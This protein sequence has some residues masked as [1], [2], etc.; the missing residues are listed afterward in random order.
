MKRTPDKTSAFHLAFRQDQ[1]HCATWQI[2]YLRFLFAVHLH[3]T[4]K[5]LAG[6]TRPPNDAYP[7]S[8]TGPPI[9][10]STDFKYDLR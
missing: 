2:S 5:L 1:E 8:R 9:R 3:E 10:I 7:F 4:N 6:R